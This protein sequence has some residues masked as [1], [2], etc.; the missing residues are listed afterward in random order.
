MDTIG[1]G[2]ALEDTHE[3]RLEL[4]CQFVKNNS[5]VCDNIKK[6]L[7]EDDVS[8]AHRLAHNL[9][10]HA[11]LIKKPNLQMLA[12]KVEASLTNNQNLLEESDMEAL[13]IEI[14]LA[15]QELI[16]IVESIE[17][18][19]VGEFDRAAFLLWSAELGELLETGNFEFINYVDKIRSVPEGGG[20]IECIENIDIPGALDELAKLMDVHG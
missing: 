3:F 20:L 17:T 1:K 10:S 7:Q 4:I 18:A 12:A 2:V 11:G 19:Q 9:K 8:Q 6:C 13:R 14:D 16:P 5:N 15:L